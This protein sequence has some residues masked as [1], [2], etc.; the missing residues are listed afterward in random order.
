MKKILVTIGLI[1]GIGGILFSLLPHKLHMDMFG[2]G[3]IEASE[4]DEHMD[5]NMNG[6]SGDHT[7]M[8]MDHHP[9]IYIMWGLIVSA[10][11]FGLA[12]TG[13][14]LIGTKKTPEPN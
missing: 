9:Q 1:L 14:K 7:E 3:M 11:G 10:I 8:V 2:G 13:W 12:F 6:K 5:D 4:M